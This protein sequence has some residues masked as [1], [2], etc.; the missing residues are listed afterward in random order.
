LRAAEGVGPFL[1][2]HAIPQREERI[3]VRMFG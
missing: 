2:E 1:V 3:A